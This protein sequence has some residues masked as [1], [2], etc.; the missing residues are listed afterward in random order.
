MLKNAFEMKELATT[1]T[2]KVV[3]KQLEE[4]AIAIELAANKG[5]RSI[6][7]GKKILEGTKNELVLKGYTIK[8]FDGGFRGEDS[9]SISW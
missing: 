2:G 1:A 4:I 7:Y 5:E 9:T 3:K 8:E 6:Y